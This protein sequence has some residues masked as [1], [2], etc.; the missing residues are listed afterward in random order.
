MVTGQALIEA[1]GRGEIAPLQVASPSP[2]AADGS[3]VAPT[4]AAAT[5]AADR[6]AAALKDPVERNRALGR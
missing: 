6:L 2:D 1:V 4:G 5:T 3:P